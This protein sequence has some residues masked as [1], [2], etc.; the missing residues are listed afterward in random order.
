MAK[1][2]NTLKTSTL[3]FLG[4]LATTAISQPALA[5]DLDWE[6]YGSLRLAAETVDADDVKDYSGLRDAYTRI[7]AKATYVINNDWS[8]MGQLEAPFDLANME[9]Q[10]A[11]DPDEDHRIGKLQ[12]SGPMGT[13]WYG[14]GW[15]A[16]YNYIQY[17]TD[18]FSS[19]YSGWDTYTSFRKSETFYYSS[20]RLSGLQFIFASTDDNGSEGDNRNQYVL[21]Y[22]NGGLSLAIGRDDF[23]NSDD[24]MIDGASAS[25]TTGPWYVAGQYQ[26]ISSDSAVTGGYY[27]DDNEAISLLVQYAIDD[28]NT[29]RG[30]VA[31]VDNNGD[32]VFQ[33]GWD[34][35]YKDDLKFFAEYYDEESPA[36]VTDDKD[37]EDFSYVGG[38]VFTVGVRYDFSSK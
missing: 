4:L 11:W 32:D 33:V 9:L 8:L 23:Q 5:Q 17:P 27:S 7:G 14:R 28:K 15:L 19:F 21:S 35:Q 3:G 1:K 16:F 31:N 12:L 13:V 38:S 34:H 37:P 26:K 20:P 24:L 36:A 18:S 22:A 25:Y 2:N 29:V 6:I 30:K 10:N